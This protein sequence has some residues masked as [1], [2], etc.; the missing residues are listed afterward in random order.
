MDGPL[1]VIDQFLCTHCNKCLEVC[2]TNA[3]QRGLLM[4]VGADGKP[5]RSRTAD[6]PITP[7]PPLSEALKNDR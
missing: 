6:D 3:I 4:E 1:A 7:T 2:P 5:I